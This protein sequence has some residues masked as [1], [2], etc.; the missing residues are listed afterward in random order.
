MGK[1]GLHRNPM[2]LRPFLGSQKHAGRAIAERRTVPRGESA[3]GSIKSGFEL[4]ELLYRGV[5][6][7][8]VVRIKSRHW[9]HQ[10]LVKTVFPGKGRV[11]MALQG[12]FILGDAR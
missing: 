6:S 9:H 12:Q 3:I 2:S 5:A 7:D 11:L 8:I 4:S 10:V 1:I